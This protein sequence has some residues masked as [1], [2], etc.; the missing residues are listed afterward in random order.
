MIGLKYE[1]KSFHHF[2]DKEHLLYFHGFQEIEQSL[3]RSFHDVPFLRIRFSFPAL[4]AKNQMDLK[5]HLLHCGIWQDLHKGPYPLATIN[6]ARTSLC[7]PKYLVALWMTI[8]AP[9]LIG[10]CRYRCIKRII[11]N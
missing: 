10:C 11:Y 7:P 5:R 9:S 2:Q 3:L 1:M 6:P 8:S 4:K